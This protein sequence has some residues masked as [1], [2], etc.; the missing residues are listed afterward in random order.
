MENAYD[1]Y[2]ASQRPVL[3]RIAAVE[4][5][6][7]DRQRAQTATAT[8]LSKK[9]KISIS[10]ICKWLKYE[11]IDPKARAN[12]LLRV[13]NM[14]TGKPVRISEDGINY[15]IYKSVVSLVKNFEKDFGCNGHYGSICRCIRNNKPYKGKIIEFTA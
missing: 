14:H 10:T 11:G 9:Y 4:K 1:A 12:E 5:R 13:N 15:K 2:G 3:L 7:C 6:I 8:D